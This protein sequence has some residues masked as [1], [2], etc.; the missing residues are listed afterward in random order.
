MTNT[1]NGLDLVAKGSQLDWKNVVSSFR[2][3]S[4]RDMLAMKV[5]CSPKSDP[6]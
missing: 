4:A 3:I 2:V 1:I 5:I 6:N